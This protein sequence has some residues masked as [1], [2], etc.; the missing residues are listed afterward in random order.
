MPNLL[1]RIEKAEQAG[2]INR[3]KIRV[4]FVRSDPVIPSEQETK[5]F[6]E[7]P[8]LDLYEI[9]IF[10]FGKPRIDDTGNQL[11]KFTGIDNGKLDS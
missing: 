7:N 6:E 4:F 1:K 3:G 10:T 8:D 5:F 11:F 9:Y 2:C